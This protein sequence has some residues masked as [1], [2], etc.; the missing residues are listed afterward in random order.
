MKK[1]GVLSVLTI[2][3]IIGFSGMAQADL[4]DGL[5]AYYPFNGNANDE[6]GN[7]NDGIVK[8]A[9]LTE[10]RFGSANSAY[11]FD[12]LD[13]YIQI[14]DV[15]ASDWFYNNFSFCAW[16]NFSNFNSDYPHIFWAEDYN[17]ILHGMGPVYGD[18][19]Y[20]IGFYQQ[21]GYSYSPDNRIGRMDSLSS[22]NID[23]WY[24]VTI[25][26]NNL[27]FTMYI[28][29][30]I[31]T[32]TSSE[33]NIVMDGSFMAIGANLHSETPANSTL[34]GTIDDVRIYNRVLSASE[35][36]EL[37]NEG[38]AILTISPPSGGY[39][40]TQNFDLT[41]IAEVD[42]LSVVG[43]NNATIDGIDITKF[44]DKRGIPGTLM[45]GGE[46]FRYRFFSRFLRRFFG[47]GTHT[48]SVTLDLSDDSNV[49]NA[50]I[51]KVKENTE[52]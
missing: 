14:D 37:Y 8:G 9:I 2:V 28:N 49:S 22:L 34:D 20:H 48:L 33:H 21:N 36:Q 47:I 46:T 52:P 45:T 6:S 38:N 42:D 15:N 23:N 24:F 35:I 18:Q 29:A 31:S 16:V 39:V 13:D 7:G 17:F 40:T 26:K 27:D 5:V 1:Y 4:N 30:E 3:G 19:Q 32:Q 51:W 41:L 25:V 44:L 43:V 11:S 12:G 10:D 50:V